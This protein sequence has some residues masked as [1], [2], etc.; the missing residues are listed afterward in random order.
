[1]TQE[2]LKLALEALEFIH[3]TGD[4]QA[5]DLCL[6]EPTITAIKEALAQPAQRPW[7]DLT[8]EDMHVVREEESCDFIA[9]AKWAVAV[10]KEK[11]T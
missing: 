6:A 1:M 9:G 4:T 11:N 2:A 5:F 8:D 10:L 3:R 7:V